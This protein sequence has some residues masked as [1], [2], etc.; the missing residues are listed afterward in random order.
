MLSDDELERS[1]AD[2]RWLRSQM[3]TYV[4]DRYDAL[5][6]E[7]RSLRAQRERAVAAITG[8]IHGPSMT[9]DARAAL[10]GVLGA[11]GVTE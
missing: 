11:L 7:V 5:L 1:A 4:P 10:V 9:V 3:V 8:A 6:A 2:I